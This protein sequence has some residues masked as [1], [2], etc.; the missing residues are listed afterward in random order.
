MKKILSIILTACMLCAAS[1]SAAAFSTKI[2]FYDTDENRWYSEYVEYLYGKDMLLGK[3]GGMF[4][5]DSGMT[6]AEVSALLIR[7]IGADTTGCKEYAAS[8][9]DANLNSWYAPYIGWAAKEGLLKGYPDGSIHPDGNISREE[10]VTLFDRFADSISVKLPDNVPVPN[11]PDKERI[12]DFA[13][14]AVT[15][16]A[17]AGIIAGDDN[18]FFNP[19]NSVTRAEASKIIMLLDK[20]IKDEKKE[21][22][23]ELSYDRNSSDLYKVW[24]A[25]HFYYAGMGYYGNMA[26]ELKDGDS[27]SFPEMTFSGVV[28]ADRDGQQNNSENRAK[29]PWYVGVN[30]LILKVDTERFPVFSMKIKYSGESKFK[31][32]LWTDRYR[33]EFIAESAR[34]EDGYSTVTIDLR[35]AAGNNKIAEAED[36]F[37]RLLLYPYGDE[38]KPGEL[39]LVYAGFFKNE[40]DADSFDPSLIADYMN[41][42][43]SKYEFDWRPFTD[44]AK[45]KYDE[46]VEDR[47][48]VIMD[49]EGGIDP[50][51]IKG[52]CYYVSSVNGDDSNNGTSP[53]TPWKTLKNLYTFLAGG[54][55]VRSKARPGDAVFFERGSVFYGEFTTEGSGNVALDAY[56]G[57]TYSAYGK[58]DKPVFTNAVDI[59]GSM[60]WEKTQYDNVWRLKERLTLPKE[61][62]PYKVPSAAY[63]YDVGNIVFNGGEGWGIKVLPAEPE[64]PYKAGVKTV[65]SGTV[66]NGYETFESGGT[67]FTNPGCL[68]H[69]LEFFHD[70]TDGSL[71]LYYDKGNPGEKFKSIIVSK[72]G[73]GIS[74]AGKDAIFDNIAVKYTGGHGITCDE[75]DNF[76]IQNC[77]IGW[78]GGSLQ[79]DGTT[80]YGNA[81]ENWGNCNSMT[82]RDSYMYQVYDGTLSSQS[83][84]SEYTNKIEFYGN[85]LTYGNSP[86][87]IWGSASYNDIQVHDNYMM[88]TGYHFGHQRPAKNASFNCGLGEYKTSNWVMED[89]VMLYAAIYCHV[90]WEFASDFVNTGMISRNNVYAINSERA[91]FYRG[92]EDITATYNMGKP[93]Y[94]KYPYTERYM[95]YLTSLGTEQ[96]SVFYWYDYDLYECE[97]DGA[98]R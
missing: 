52:D 7:M 89:N 9:P 98:F 60:D 24:G 18:G 5:P 68:E 48:R 91:F 6:R 23:P 71:Y 57:V 67:E 47:L 25:K 37:V 59:N 95:R 28:G 77:E 78:I 2:P 34:G 15:R 76:L 17:K 42:Y 61:G 96:G 13:E 40:S 38:A 29:A 32:E 46:A 92:F 39:S 88:Y 87:E 50:S 21:S 26:A 55:I 81:V 84:G 36:K 14:I 27:S 93:L 51:T 56:P 41:T 75:A 16:L 86:I 63:Y 65:D 10:I 4:E 83:G 43:V 82:V 31:A 80:R 45:G 20:I 3:G 58:G 69:N 73:K 66:F 12:G 11:F 94:A 49:D 30:P 1:V 53:E 19:Q 85:V 35:A 79:G 64:N 72:R 74:S 54:S 70:F 90:G 97:K 33:N 8:F 62:Y 22:I 44:T